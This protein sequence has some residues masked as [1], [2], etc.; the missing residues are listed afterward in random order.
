MRALTHEVMIGIRNGVT[1]RARVTGPAKLMGMQVLHP[2]VHFPMELLQKGSMI[3]LVTFGN[4]VTT[5]SFMEDLGVWGVI[6]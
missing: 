5:R 4:G 3:S 6:C 2:L 1:G